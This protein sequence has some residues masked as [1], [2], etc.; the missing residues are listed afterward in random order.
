MQ[1]SRVQAAQRPSS[2]AAGSGVRNERSCRRSG[3][4]PCCAA[5]GTPEPPPAAPP[6]YF[7]P[8]RNVSAVE[9]Q[10][11][12]QSRNAAPLRNQNPQTSRRAARPKAQSAAPEPETFSARSPDASTRI[13]R[14][15]VSAM[16]VL[17]THSY[18]TVSAAAQ[19]PSS[20]AAGSVGDGSLRPK[21]KL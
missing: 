6:K 11:L 7:E 13:Q 4:A 20:P 1:Q 18:D 21:P 2:P 8:S 5:V 17:Q 15:Q 14:S 3:A 19:R 16:G 10:T 9:A 12:H